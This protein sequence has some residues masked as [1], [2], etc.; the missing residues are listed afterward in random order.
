[1]GIRFGPAG[2]SLSFYQQGYKSSV[3]APGWL[4]KRGLSAY[5]YSCTK[6]VKIKEDTAA[7]IGEEAY[8][9]DIALSI[10]AP[11]FVNMASSDPK[12]RRK[13]TEY[14][15]QS[16]QAAR[17]MGAKRVVFH[18]GSCGKTERKMAL[19]TAMETLKRTIEEADRCGFGDIVLCPET[20]G[21]KN[22]LG[23]L[24]E[25]LEMCLLDK[26]LMPAVDFGH[27][28]AYTGGGLNSS[29][30]YAAVVESIENVLGW[31]YVKS[32]HVHFSRVEYTKGG[33]KK[34]WTFADTQYGPEFEPLAR[35]L[36][37]KKMEPVII[38]ESRGTMAEDACEMK[39]IFERMR[40]EM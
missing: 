25:V 33:E 35:V 26:R 37:K 5:E 10:H 27:I 3:E 40:K 29:S 36:A 12:K 20:L 32:L 19:A 31:Q 34:H 28:H 24:D 9:N 18:P 17:W 7:R 22:Q 13:S 2:N 6:G 23:S 30:E 15:L 14:I 8:K 38:C 1:M 4:A 39:E 11:Y 21:K 16:M